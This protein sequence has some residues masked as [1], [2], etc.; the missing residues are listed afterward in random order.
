VNKDEIICMMRE[1]GLIRTKYAPTFHRLCEIAAAAERK[2][3]QLDGIHTCSNECQRPACVA[4]R[5]A[6]AAERE[7]C[8]KICEEPW[9]GHPYGIAKQIRA[10]GNN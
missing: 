3:M 9:Q 1:A 2:K 6:V 8:A 10:R 7:A 4:V 5:E